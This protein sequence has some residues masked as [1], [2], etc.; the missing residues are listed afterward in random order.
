MGKPS[1]QHQ[2]Q[3][4]QEATYGGRNG[5]EVWLSW[6]R[7]WDV[8][9][10]HFIDGRVDPLWVRAEWERRGGAPAVGRAP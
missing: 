9:N 3:Q 2:Q 10:N 4:Q 1:A 7:A 8:W 6:K 5:K